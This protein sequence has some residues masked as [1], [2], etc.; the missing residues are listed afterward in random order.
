MGLPATIPDETI[1]KIKPLPEGPN[2]DKHSKKLKPFADIES[3]NLMLLL[4]Q[5][6][7]LKLDFQPLVLSTIADIQALLG[8]DELKDDSDK[9][10]FKAGDEMDEDIQQ[11][12]EEETNY[13]PITE[14]QLV[15]NLQNFYKVLYAQ[16]AEDYW[17]KHEEVS[18]SYADLKSSLSIQNHTEKDV[19]KIFS[20]FKE[21]QDDVKEDPA[22]NKKVLEAAEAYIKN[23]INLIELLSLVNG[24]DFLGLKSSIESLQAAALRQDEHLA[25]WAKSST[26]MAQSLGPRMTNIK[27]TQAVIQ[28]DITYLKQDTFEI[29]SM[30][31]EIFDAFKG[32]SS[33]APSSSVPTTT[34]AISEDDMVTKEAVMKK[35]TKEPKVKNVKEVPARASRAIS[36]SILTGPVADITLPPQPESSQATPKPDRG[37]GIFTDDTESLKKLV[38]ASTV[39]HPD[40]DEA[41]RV[42]YEIHRKL[43][44]L[45]NDEI[46]D[47]LDKEEKIKKVTEEAKLLE[48]SKP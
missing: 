15:R 34:L 28:S 22:L 4:S 27:L 1:S 16:V 24:F 37:K 40:L 30:M 23:Y 39:V 8:D 14:R 10:V 11:A 42:P 29:K 17:E 33:F 35:P 13:M 25:R 20:S 5:G 47:H 44:H 38:K 2:E 31:T 46:Q 26:S 18:A 32:Q 45:T 7:M 3:L 19:S 36:I 43:Y 41:D 9:D 48:M 6:L 21:I 12:D